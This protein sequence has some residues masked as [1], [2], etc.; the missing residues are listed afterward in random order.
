MNDIY[1]SA[2]VVIFSYSIAE[3]PLYFEYS[4]FKICKDALLAA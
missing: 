4:L 1:I 2:T 3:C